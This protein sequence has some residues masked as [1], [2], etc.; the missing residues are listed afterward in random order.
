MA[1]LRSPPPPPNNCVLESSF[2]DGAV[3]VELADVADR[4]FVPDAVAAALDV[5]ALAGESLVDAL[6]D[7]LRSRTLLLVLD[8]CEHVLGSVAGLATTLLREAPRLRAVAT[9]REPLRIAGEVVFRVPSLAIPDPDSLASPAESLAYE[10]VQLFAE[11][12]AAAMPGFSVDAD[13][14]ADVARICF[15]LDGLPLAIELAAGRLG[16]LDPA[17]LAERLDSRFGVLRATSEAAPTRQ[18][19]LAATLDWSHG[20]LDA[21]EQVLFRRLSVFAGGF[22]LAAAE[23]VCADDRLPGET[24]VP[25]LARLVDKSLVAVDVHRRERRYRLLE[26]VRAYASDRLAEAGES[27]ALAARHARWAL[28]LAEGAGDAP[29]L[30]RDA[31]NL[32][33][34]LD[35][36]V[37]HEPDLA[38]PFCLAPWP[39]WLRRTDLAE[40]HQRFL[41]ALA[42]GGGSAA[43]R[44]DALLAAAAIDVRAGSMACGLG[45]ARESLQ[46]AVDRGDG[47]AEWRAVHFLGGSVIAHDEPATALEWFARGLQIAD[48][49]GLPAARALGVYSMGV[50]RALLGEA[51]AAEELVAR[52]IEEFRALSDSSERVP[53]PTNLGETFSTAASDR[54]AVR[55]VFEDT[56]Q[57]FVEISCKTAIGYLL[58][59]Q[60][61]ILRVV[62][63]L[64]RARALL[65]ESRA[66][67]ESTGDERGCADV[68]VRQAYVEIAEGA[69][70]AA[71]A[72]LEQAL[73]Q[74]RGLNDRRRVGLALQGLGLVETIAGDHVRAAER[75][76][77]AEE[78][79]RRSGDRWGLAT[80]LWRI[81]D[82]ALA[83]GDLDGAEAA[84]QRARQILD[85]AQ[86]ERWIALTLAGLAELALLRGD[87]DQADALLLEA[88][89]RFRAKHD[90]LGAAAVEGR[91]QDL[92]RRR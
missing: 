31:A 87:P 81:A 8:N 64:A 45:H 48:R 88:G 82:L 41:D 46:M 69:L 2:A 19:T 34:G 40:A 79:F 11:R 36:V 80:T 61:Q 42:A 70:P 15:R 9:S 29:G 1:W 65:A 91:R 85:E 89:E 16:A 72:C 68:A 4:R 14:A 44:A 32:R 13:N 92:L 22:E 59:N 26:T 73:E 55:I 35:W 17:A 47:R 56:L 38:V 75:L 53:A 24:V 49:E 20:L 6:A 39:F 60:A 21:D 51:A 58:A 62:G 78:L 63:D 3:L 23:L 74:R 86:R 76:A 50:A 33:A 25:L 83:R 27:A 18:Q 30:D 7:F 5:R 71:R 57:P 43:L 54:A 12:G 10:A 84:L 67:F 28:A 37:A 90:E 66:C 77:E 52:S